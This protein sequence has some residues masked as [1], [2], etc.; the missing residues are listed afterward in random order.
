MRQAGADGEQPWTP[1]AG[2]TLEVVWARDEG[3][4]APVADPVAAVDRDAYVASRRTLGGGHGDGRANYNATGAQSWVLVIL[5]VVVACILLLSP[6][7]LPQVYGE[8]YYH[9]SRCTGD[10]TTLGPHG[11]VACPDEDKAIFRRVHP[12]LVLLVSTGIVLVYLHVRRLLS[13]L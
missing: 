6:W 13:A 1:A 8:A 7:P 5:L 4:F 3:T 11:L 10:L 2:Q 9:W 12:P